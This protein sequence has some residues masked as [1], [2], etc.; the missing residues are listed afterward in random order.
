MNVLCRGCIHYNFLVLLY[1]IAVSITG[2]H[3]ML[4]KID[5]SPAIPHG[6]DNQF[7]GGSSV[8]A[9]PFGNSNIFDRPSAFGTRNPFDLNVQRMDLYKRMSTLFPEDQVRTVLEYYPHET[10]LHKLCAALLQMF[11]DGGKA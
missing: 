8:D 4:S 1:H 7:F 2:I 3:R 6:E 5:Q 10:N 9:D 11:P